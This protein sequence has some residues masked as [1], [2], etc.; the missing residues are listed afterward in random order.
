LKQIKIESSPSSPKVHLNETQSRKGDPVSPEI[1]ELDK[2][3]V[4]L[5]KNK[6]KTDE[7]CKKVNLVNDQETGRCF[8]VIQKVD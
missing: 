1:D 6:D 8:K 4:D 7:L 5:N 3:I 2:K